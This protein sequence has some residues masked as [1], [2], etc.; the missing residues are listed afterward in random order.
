MFQRPQSV[1]GKSTDKQFLFEQ[2]HHLAGSV[3]EV[4]TLNKCEGLSNKSVAK[5]ILLLSVGIEALPLRSNHG[6]DDS[7]LH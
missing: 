6:S 2:H 1:E 5:M 3:D 7:S 4:I